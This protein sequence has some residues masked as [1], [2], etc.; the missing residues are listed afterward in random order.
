[1]KLHNIISIICLSCLAGTM[2][3]AQQPR[4]DTI[5]YARDYYRKRV[6][7][8]KEE[9]LST[10]KIIFLGNS[11]TEYGEWEK[12]LGDSTVVNRGIAADNTYGVLER[13]DDII[14]RKPSKLFVEIGLNDVAQEIPSDSIVA[15]IVRI[16]SRCRQSSPGLKVYVHGLSPTNDNCKK[17][18]PQC[19]GK[20]D[21]A[22]AVNQKLV[23]EAETNSFTFIDL[24][25][26]FEDKEGNLDKKYAREDGLHLNDLGYKTWIAYLRKIKAIG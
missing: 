1:M 13:L 22:R 24:Y 12:L 21:L 14:V 23:K 17:Y 7:A 4:Y 26:L 2:V 8:F 18:Y 20:N 9:H 10:G 5:R 11:I 25:K 19:F 16:V 6:N 15:N 3:V